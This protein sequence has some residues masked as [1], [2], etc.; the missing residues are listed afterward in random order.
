MTEFLLDDLRDGTARLARSALDAFASDITAHRH[1][2]CEAA[3]TAVHGT[4]RPR[5][6][7]SGSR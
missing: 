2:R 5:H 6:H 7:T 4:G 3:L 1:G